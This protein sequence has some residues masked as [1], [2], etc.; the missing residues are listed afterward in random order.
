MYDVIFD[1]DVELE[2]YIIAGAP[3]GGALG[4]SSYRSR[5]GRLGMC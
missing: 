5:V 1:E 3:Y 4:R 2:N